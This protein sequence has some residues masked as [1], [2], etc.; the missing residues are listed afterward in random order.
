MCPVCRTTGLPVQSGL[1]GRGD[2]ILQFDW[3][4]GEILDQIDRLGLKE[5]TL[6]ILTSD[7]GPVVDDGYRD[8]SVE[9]LGDHMPSGPLRGGKYSAFDAGTRVPFIVRW[10]GK[11]LPGVSESLMSQIDLMAT[12]ASIAGA[13]LPPDSA[14]DSFDASHVLMGHVSKDREYVVE[15]AASGTLSII[16]DGWKYIEP[17]RGARYNRYTNIELGNDTIPQLYNLNNDLGEE[18]NLARQEPEMSEKLSKL[19]ESVREST[20]SRP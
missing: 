19:L 5:S 16:A 4:V 14:P 15:H 3:C 7:N 17:G 1:G 20:Y 8:L 13:K 6:V 18:Q 9:Q 11:V 10:P 12:L 2:A